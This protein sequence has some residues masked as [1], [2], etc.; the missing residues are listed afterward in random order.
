[1]LVAFI[2]IILIVL[3]VVLRYVWINVYFPH[4]MKKLEEA[5]ERG[6]YEEVL[7]TVNSFSDERRKGTESQWL[8]SR[9]YFDQTQYVMAI[10]HLNEILANNVYTDEITPVNV[11]RLLAYSYEYTG[12]YKK[13]ME[14]YM[15]IAK[16]DDS[17]F[18]AI[19][20]LAKFYFDR[21]EYNGAKIYLEKALALNSSQPDL[22]Y[23]LAKVAYEEKNFDLSFDYVNKSISLDANNNN[24]TLLRGKV[25]YKL[26]NYDEAKNDLL[27]TSNMANLKAESLIYLGRVCYDLGEIDEALNFFEKGLHMNKDKDDEVLY[28]RYLYADALVKSH[29]IKE[30][31]DQW[32][33]VRKEKKMFLDVEEKIEMYSQVL[34][35]DSIQEVLKAGLPDYVENVLY[36][37]FAKNSFT[38]LETQEVSDSLI[39]VLTQKKIG[40]GTQSYKSAFAIDSSCHRLG[41]AEVENFLD[42]I[43]EQNASNSYFVSFGDFENAVKLTEY[44]PSIELINADKF[45]DFVKGRIKL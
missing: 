35:I 1:M 32:R 25:H 30:A 19:F 43:K 11:R 26:K 39:Y 21:K 6:D 41:K 13:A 33:A 37:S 36:K 31:L 28:A 16:L 42:F 22:L 4:Q 44:S 23:M 24:A 7:N 5:Y 14:E 18:D 34:S 20:K 3:A 38:I 9:V 27:I 2:I 8:L 12:K 15:E 17:D 29:R 45:D 40:G 10:A